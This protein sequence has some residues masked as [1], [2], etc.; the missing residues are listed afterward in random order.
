MDDAV[1]VETIYRDK[2]GRVIKCVKS[3]INSTPIA[4][5]ASVAEARCNVSTSDV[6]TSPIDDVITIDRPSTLN[7]LEDASIA[8]ESTP[9]TVCE[10]QVSLV[11]EQQASLQPTVE[12]VK[13]ANSSTVTKL[14]QNATSANKGL[15][16]PFKKSAPNEVATLKKVSPL[17][18]PSASIPKQQ[19]TEAAK[20]PKPPP[21]VSKSAEIMARLQ[22]SMAKD[23]VLP[24]KEVKSKVFTP[25]LEGIKGLW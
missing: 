20:R 16:L 2:S 8:D 10:D 13:N 19:T 6:Q 5:V 7:T 12:Q 24:K 4:N 18:G 22:Q 1:I 14:K 11:A 9:T 3:A 17:G 25:A 15:K 21:K 23:K